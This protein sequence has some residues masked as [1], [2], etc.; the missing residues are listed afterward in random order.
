MFYFFI[1]CRT[2]QREY[3]GTDA[4]RRGACLR[5]A[6]RRSDDHRPQM[7]PVSSSFPIY[8]VGYISIMYT[9][10]IIR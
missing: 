1:E 4:R 9:L 7:P 3:L 5:H 8:I 2:E 6:G 10:V